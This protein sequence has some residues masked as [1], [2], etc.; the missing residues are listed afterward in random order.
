MRRVASTVTSTRSC[1]PCGVE[2]CSVG[3]DVLAPQIAYGPVRLEQGQRAE[4]LATY[5]ERLKSIES[6]EPFEVGIY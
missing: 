3:F 5:A 1:G 6:E 4:L 2:C